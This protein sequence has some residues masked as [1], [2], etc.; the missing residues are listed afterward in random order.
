MKASGVSLMPPAAAFSFSFVAQRLELGDVGLVELRDVRDVHPA[1]MQPRAGDPLDARQRLGLDR[2][3]LREVDGRH[4]RAARRRR[5]RSARPGAR[6]RAAA[7]SVSAL[8]ERLDVLVRD[9]ALEAVPVT[10]VRSTPSSRANLRTEGPAWARENPGSLMGGRSVAAAA[11]HAAVACRGAAS[12]RRAGAA[13][14]RGWRGAAAAAAALARERLRRGRAGSA[15]GCSWAGA[16]AAARRSR[17]CWRRLRLRRR[18]LGAHRRDQI[19]RVETVPP[20][21]TWIFSMT[22]P[23]VDGTSIVAFSV[24]SVTSGA[25]GSMALARL[26]ENVDDGDVLEVAHVGHSHFD[27]AGSRV[28]RDG[29]FRLSRERAWPDRRRAPSSPR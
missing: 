22:P 4:R 29:A 21:A 20:L 27:E 13:T 24:S 25:S 9:P 28:H 3:E 14:C 5:A 23:T 18:R 6:C 17:R 15:R 8:D 12:L 10:R 16:L 7:P 19:A 11:R 2:P 26:D 1:R